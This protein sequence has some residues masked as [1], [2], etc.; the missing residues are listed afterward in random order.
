MV[1]YRLVGEEWS[2]IVKGC[3][4]WWVKKNRMGIES[5]GEEGSW[6]VKERL[7]IIGETG[8]NE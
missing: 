6:I 5:G 1:A 3:I 2:R 4:G 7:K 8:Y